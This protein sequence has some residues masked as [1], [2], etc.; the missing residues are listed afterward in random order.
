MSAPARARVPPRRAPGGQ[1]GSGTAPTCSC[2]IPA[3]VTCRRNAEERGFRHECQS[4]APSSLQTGSKGRFPLVLPLVR[5]GGRRPP[6]GRAEPALPLCRPRG[7]E[8][9]RV[10]QRPGV[11]AGSPEPPRT[12]PL[13]FPRPCWG[14]ARARTR[15][16]RRTGS[17]GT[18]GLGGGS[19]CRSGHLGSPRRPLASPRRAPAAPRVTL[20][21]ARWSIRTHFQSHGS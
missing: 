5:G 12:E 4:R 15:R 8:G 2:P 17:P 7:R 10:G 18:P 19:R 16:R 9:A 11:Q 1:R 21:P 6:K 20:R 13:P 14:S 3:D